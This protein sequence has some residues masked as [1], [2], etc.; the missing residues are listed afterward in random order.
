MEKT[1][2]T[3]QFYRT[4]KALLVLPLFIL[5]L[6]TLGFWKL[7][8]APANERTG[9][10]PGLNA[11]L[12]GAKFDKHEKQGNKM[13]FYDQ[14]KQDSARAQSNDN[15]PLVKQFGFKQPQNDVT[16]TT[17]LTA[18]YADPNV[19]RINQK[20][21]DINKQISQPI[22]T[23]VTTPTVIKPQ[24]NKQLTEQVNRLEGLMKNINTNQDADPQIQQLSQMLE[25][26][27][28]IQHPEST[29]PTT[30][31]EA[32]ASPFKAIPAFIDGNQKVLQGGAVRLKLND[33][34]S[35]KGQLIP[36]GTPI[37]G[38][39]NITNQRLLLEIK[40]IR[41][42]DAIIPV[43]LT[44]YSEDSMPG[45]PAPEAELAGAAGTGAGNTLSGMQFLSMDQSLATQAAAGGIE[46]AKG[47]LSK[48]AKRIKVHLKN[49]YPVLLRNNSH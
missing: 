21:A 25:K 1:I 23:P 6:V 28:Q 24:D 8:Q 9:P 47:L 18:N 16:E 38:T 4:R 3:P 33:S 44:V 40:N 48:K 14:A 29:K 19:T 42:G 37:F 32:S 31:T 13:S 22:V 27:Q 5:P 36:K 46:A 34:L 45:I 12:P 43:N 10:N 11:S 2:R 17:P 15:N 20:L 35:I 7:H 30:P 41:L 49:E 39:A 26:I